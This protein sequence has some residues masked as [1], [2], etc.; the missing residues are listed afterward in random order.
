MLKSIKKRI[1]SW[2]LYH[3]LKMQNEEESRD[4]QIL[5]ISTQDGFGLYAVKKGFTEMIP[6]DGT[7]ISGCVIFSGLTEQ[8]AKLKL[9]SMGRKLYRS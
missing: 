4:W 8:D 6:D 2:F 9:D 3:I 5:V 7:F 1:L